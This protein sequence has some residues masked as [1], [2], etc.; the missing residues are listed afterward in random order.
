VAFNYL[1]KATSNNNALAA[2]LIWAL[3]GF[4]FYIFMSNRKYDLS[5]SSKPQKT[6]TFEDIMGL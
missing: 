4:T 5:T 3:I 2:M 1:T 6:I